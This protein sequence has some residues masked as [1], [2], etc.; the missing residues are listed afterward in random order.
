M[1]TNRFLNTTKSITFL[2]L[3]SA[4][5]ISC[6]DDDPAPV[7]EEETITRVT[8]TFTESGGGAE[9]TY[10]YNVGEAAPIIEMTDGV[11]YD[12][13]ITFEDAS[14]PV[15]VED[16]TAEVEEEADDHYVFYQINDASFTLESA[17]TD[18]E[19]TD[20]TPIGLHTLWTPTGTDDGTVTV[21]LIHEPTSKT[22][23]VRDDLGGEDDVQITFNVTIN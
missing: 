3:F 6:S 19:D 14:D 9:Q 1:K 15:D 12:V 13:S 22:G 10:I 18:V 2:L 8:L 7:N 16:I 11:A 5:A 4:L 20:G 17:D 23:D 21:Y